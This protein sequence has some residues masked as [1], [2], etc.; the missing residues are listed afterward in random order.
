MRWRASGPLLIEAVVDEGQNFEPKLS[1]R[2]LPDGTMV[3]PELDDMF[4][5]IPKEELEEIRRKCREI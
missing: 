2:A 4:P 5:F 3:S 1:S